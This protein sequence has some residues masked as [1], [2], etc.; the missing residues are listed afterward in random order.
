MSD[1]KYDAQIVKIKED[2]LA[3][4]RKY[5]EA[6]W[7]KFKR[8]GKTSSEFK[9]YHENPFTPGISVYMDGNKLNQQISELLDEII[10][11]S[12]KRKKKA[13]PSPSS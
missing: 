5:Y 9:K 6:S 7:E 11:A 3:N 1:A 13:T 10:K 2:I 4:T 12:K 8:E